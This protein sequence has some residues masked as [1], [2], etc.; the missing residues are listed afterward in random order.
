MLKARLAAIGATIGILAAAP[1]A[2]SAPSERLV[3]APIGTVKGLRISGYKG[4]LV[5][6]PQAG[7]NLTVDAKLKSDEQSWRPTIETVD[8]W[9]QVSVQG[10]P[11]KSDWRNVQ[12]PPTD[13][14][15]RGPSVPLNIAWKE[16]DITVKGWKSPVTLSH[17]KGRVVAEDNQAPLRLTTLEG[18]AV[19]GRHK[20]RVMVDNYNARVALKNVDGGL[21]LENF[22][23]SLTVEDSRGDISLKASKGRNQITGHKGRFEFDL[24]QGE[25]IISGSEGAVRGQAEQ[26]AVTTEIKGVA[27]VKIRSEAARVAVLVPKTSG[28]KVDLGT[29]DGNFSVSYPLKYDRVE[30]VKLMKGS[31]S[32]KDGGSIFVRT[33]SGDI[34]LKPIGK[35]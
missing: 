32:G 19:V 20:G 28:A 13:F 8:G 18:E 10:P 26:G 33:R 4:N 29:N 14:E 11:S 22:S 9:I 7:G 31:L 23:G 5:F 34:R 16:G 30:K 1:F 27:D 15:I 17:H 21:D 3:D 25:I 12:P 24:A 2:L 35:N 6:I